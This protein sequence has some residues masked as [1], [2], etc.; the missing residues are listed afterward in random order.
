MEELYKLLGVDANAPVSKLEEAVTKLQADNTSKVS[1]IAGLRSRISK[2]EERME[3]IAQGAEESRVKD[4]LTE[5]M[6]KTGNHVGKDHIEK[7]Q[8]KASSYI[9]AH[10]DEERQA[11]M[12]DM[13]SICIAYGES[14]DSNHLEAL[15]SGRS[16]KEASTAQGRIYQKA[17]LLIDSGKAKSWEEAHQMVAEETIEIED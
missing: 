13:E 14:T 4:L 7:L 2:T 10:T 17:K 12:E 11:I 9:R 6:N 5:V 8:I 15:I 1:I 16:G 3:A